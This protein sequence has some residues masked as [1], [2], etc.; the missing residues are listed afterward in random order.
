M[1][2]LLFVP[3]DGGKKL[4]KALGCGADAV[5]VDL[6]DSIAHDR[7]APASRIGISTSLTSASETPERRASEVMMQRYYRAAKTVTQLNTIVLQNIGA[8]LLPQPDGVSR[9]LNERF[10]VRGELLEVPPADVA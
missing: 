4:E 8:R 6:E 1:R 10:R 3:A 5:I 2:S 9:S 7:K